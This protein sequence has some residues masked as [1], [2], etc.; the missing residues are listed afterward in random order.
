MSRKGSDMY[1]GHRSRDGRIQPL[2]E[3]LAEVAQLSAEFAE[4][5]GAREHAYR[6]GMLHDAGKYSPAGQKRMKDPEHTAKV[7]HS[8]AGAKIAVEECRDFFGASAVAGHHGGMMNLGTKQ[9]A[10]GDGTL[11]SRCR[12]ILKEENDPGAFW[13][14]NKDLVNK[15]AL[16]PSWLREPDKLDQFK[17]QFYTRMLFS[18]LVDADFLDTERFMN[19]GRIQRGIDADLEKLL[20]RLKRH[21]EPWLKNANAS[22]I[23]KKRNEILKN[24][25]EAGEQEKGL[26][27]LTVPT[28]GGKTIASLAF[29]LKHAVRNGMKRILYVIP[30]TSIIDQNAKVFKSILGDEAVL[31]HHSGMDPVY[32]MDIENESERRKAMATENW[33]APVIVTTSVQF[34]ESLFSNRPSKCRKLHTIADSVIIF[35]EAQMLPLPYLKP[36]VA[37]IAELIAHYGVSAVLCTA[38]QPSLNPL[39]SEFLPQIQ[40]REIS[41]D[42][43]EL[44]EFFRRVKYSRAGTMTEEKLAEAVSQKEE[45]LCIVNTRKT[46]REV[47]ERLPEKGRYHL[48]TKMTAYDRMRVLSEIREQL[49]KNAPCRVVSTSLIE[50]GVD[51]D[52]PEVW[53]EMAGLDS[54]LQAAGRCNREGKREQDESAVVVF[55]LKGKRLRSIDQN[56]SA[57]EKAM[58]EKCAWDTSSVLRVYYDQLY[59]YLKELIEADKIMEECRNL[60]FESLAKDFHIMEENTWTI[61]IPNERNETDLNRLR[62]GEIDRGG[63]RRLGRFAVNVYE[64]EWKAMRNAGK[65][66][67]IGEDMAILADQSAY[68]EECGLQTE[69]EA[70]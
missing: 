25:L 18:C 67:M 34:F 59:L 65:L 50:A 2:Q 5:F 16:F 62:N 53:R 11:M 1:I 44:Q 38:T 55:S 31:E 22:P 29:A 56:V 10:E 4:A 7:D 52:F 43:P 45:I 66:E 12:K 49:A 48:S 46:A 61:Y 35:D 58:D 9:S 63:M 39:F 3:H 6:T 69:T 26:F 68:S 64:S 42:V 20:D 57:A 33:D 51:V 60:E 41:R 32:D 27:T 36:C 37:A 28:G 40:P 70:G 30:Y 17:F 24:C 13:T 23:N 14:E 19:E 21:V 15:D 47:F 54:I 8:A